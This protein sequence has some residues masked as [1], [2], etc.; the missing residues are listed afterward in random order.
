MPP[1]GARTIA[2]GGTGAAGAHDRARPGSGDG[3]SVGRTAITVLSGVQDRQGLA[4]WREYGKLLLRVLRYR[5][6]SRDWFAF[7]NSHPL[8]Q[9]LVGARPKLVGKAF[10]PYLTN[11]LSACDRVTVLRDHYTFIAHWNLGALCLRAAG[12][13]VPLAS[14]TGRSGR[15]YRIELRAV[16]P[17]DREGE[18]ALQIFQGD[19]LIYS[20]AFTAFQGPYGAVLGVGCLQ[21]PRGAGGLDA[22]RQATKELHGW[23]PKHLLLRL[24]VAVGYAFGCTSLRL[25]GNANR[26]VRRAQQQGKVFADYDGFWLECGAVRRTDGDFELPCAGVCEPDLTLTPSHK[27]SAARRRHDVL[28][29]LASA[30]LAAFG[31]GAAG[32]PRPSPD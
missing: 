25:V 19:Q 21:G 28:A 23:R 17:L 18:L 5:R 29:N 30:A 9:A 12:A 6:A 24:L 10:R 16:Q 3:Q 14:V 13:G 22:V 4:R 15:E 32:V 2:V 1:A 11:T 8:A 7:L 27:R 20:I 26:A 31:R